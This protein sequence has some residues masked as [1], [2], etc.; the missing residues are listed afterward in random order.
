MKKLT[1]LLVALL[2]AVFFSA[3]KKDVQQENVFPQ[4]PVPGEE[5]PAGIESRSIK[6]VTPANINF[7]LSGA[8]LFSL[9]FETKIDDQGVVK[10]A[11]R[12]G[13]PGIAYVFD[14]NHN[15]ILAG[16]ITDSTSTISAASTAEVLLYFGMGTA[17]QPY[18]VMGKFI[19][20]IGKVTGVQQWKDEFEGMFKSDPLVL[21][22][23]AFA[24]AL[25]VKAEALIASGQIA[26]RPA[27]ITVDA[28]DIRSGLQ[29]A[30]A[31]LNKFNITNTIRRRA[32][33]FVY[34]MKYKDLNGISHTVNQNISGSVTS[35]A[36]IKLSPTLAIREYKGVIQDWAAGK[37]LEFAATESGPIDIPFEE[38]ESEADFKVRVIGPGLPVMKALTSD[39][40]ERLLNLSLQTLTFDYLLPFMLD[41][42]GHKETLQKMNSR[43][44]LGQN[45]ENL[46]ALLKKTSDL[47]FTIPA[48]SDAME[49]GDYTKAF[50]EVVAG[51]VNG[52]M[53]T[54]ADEWIRYLYKN[55]GDAVM[56]MGGPDIKP[57]QGDLFKKRAEKLLRV[58]ET[59][60]IGMKLI[61][62]SRLTKAILASDALEEWDLK[63]REV[64]VNLEPKEFT[65]GP[66]DQKALTTYIKTTIGE[67]QLVEYH[68]ET[69]GKYGYLWDDRG[70]KGVAFT[71]SL[72]EAWYLC[73]ALESDL[74]QGE[75]IDTIKVTAYLKQGQTLTR[76]GTATS[77]AKINK[78]IFTLGWTPNVNIWEVEE[79]NGKVTYSASNPYFT[80]E[81]TERKDAK[82]YSIRIVRKDGTK[83][84]PTVYVPSQLTI[85]NGI[86]RYR[87][88]IGGLFLK[89]GMNAS[90]RDA[91]ITRQEKML[92]DYVGNGIEVTVLY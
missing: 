3:C 11:Y 90:Q 54:A 41:M 12:K 87:L 16:F 27:D 20:S 46:E 92:A 7:D 23:G 74:S 32:Q 80:A 55:V 17:F 45:V 5:L 67:D 64:Q 34:K 61:D 33:A 68:W 14:K 75:N 62:Y 66:L 76:I 19:N 60:D 24:Q 78:D 63:A 2:F 25:K 44:S 91:E 59:I 57:D 1:G 22:K 47:V 31:G 15:I 13:Y 58:L 82:S 70:H 8:T 86:V 52:R 85:E 84:A 28:N 48:A 53:R 73:N 36:S 49:A 9:S 81:F 83:A 10:A 51:L 18:E 35:I 65:L 69:T 40:K 30:E 71:S 42:V 72:K 38:N 88:G 56:E 50:R 79:S 4:P 21:H 89:I 6:V 37:G 29:L 39:E 26:G 43:F 77:L